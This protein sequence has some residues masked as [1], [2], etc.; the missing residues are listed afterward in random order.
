MLR[1]FITVLLITPLLMIAQTKAA[2]GS[3][4]ITSDSK[5]IHTVMASKKTK[6]E[7]I[8]LKR[9]N[10]ENHGADVT[11]NE[12]GNFKVTALFLGKTKKIREGTLTRKQMDDL[13]RLIEKS[14]YYESRNE[15]KGPFKTEFSWWGY[16]L[17]VKTKQWGKSVRFHSEDDTVPEKLKELVEFIMK[18]TK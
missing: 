6:I 3:G 13:S 4:I 5:I 18:S 11:I 14:R 2:A 1:V 17:T 8:K 16:Q 12:K 15:F 10:W 9:R 7:F